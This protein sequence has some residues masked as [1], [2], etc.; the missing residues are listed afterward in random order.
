MCLVNH[1]QK[2]PTT[3]HNNQAV[4]P[5][6]CSLFCVTCVTMDPSWQPRTGAAQRR[7]QRRLR[8]WWRH[9]QQSIAA[10]LATFKH[11]SAL[12]GQK[13]AGGSRDALH[14]DVLGA[15]S[16]PGGRCA[17]LLPRRR[18]RATCRRCL[19][20]LDRRSGCCD[21]PVEQMADSTPV[22]PMLEAP[23]QQLGCSVVGSVLGRWEPL[24]PQARVQ[25]V[26][27]QAAGHCRDQARLV[28]ARHRTAM[29]V[30]AWFAAP[31]RASTL[32]RAELRSIASLMPRY[33][34]PGAGAGATDPGADRG[35]GGSGS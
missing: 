4:Y 29:Q 9:E 15:S 26:L 10:G 7:K 11:H 24:P 14:G 1:R 17:A 16:S 34:V 19:P 8:S 12:R 20:C 23:V 33:R 13:T 5:Q 32:T 31:V 6:E 35:G 27:E 30:M 2:Q 22:V 3:T 28:D 18:R 25:P 21:T